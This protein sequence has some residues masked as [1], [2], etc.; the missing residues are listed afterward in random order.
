MNNS[1]SLFSA[2]LMSDK[3]NNWLLKCLIEVCKLGNNAKSYWFPA[4]VHIKNVKGRYIHVYLSFGGNCE[5]VMAKMRKMTRG[6]TMRA[7]DQACKQKHSPLQPIQRITYT[8]LLGV[9]DRQSANIGQLTEF[10]DQLQWTSLFM[11]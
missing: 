10:T 4:V 11:A 1:P 9:R 2:T 8:V 7:T 6:Q 5:R 3:C